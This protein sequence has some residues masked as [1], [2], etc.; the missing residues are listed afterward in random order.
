MGKINRNLFAVLLFIPIL[1]GVFA[2]CDNSP[3]KTGTLMDFVPENAAVVF[4]ISNFE[5]L[6]ADMENSA[7][8]S[9]FENTEIYSYFTKKDKILKN[10]HPTSQSLLSINKVNDSVSAYTFITKH[11]DKLFQLD[12]VKNKSVETLTLDK[13]SF[14]RVSIDENTAYSTIIDSVLVVSS[15]QQIIQDIL[16]GKTEHDATFKKVFNLPSSNDFTALLRGKKEAIN[17]STKINFT[18]WSALDITFSSENFTATG[19]SMATDTIPQLLNIFEGQIPQQNDVALLIPSDAK[20]ALSFTFNDAESIQEKIRHYKGDTKPI[21]TTGIFGSVSEAG[22]IELKQESAIF[23]KSIDALLT[24]DALARFVTSK[25]SFREVDIKSFSEPKLFRE[26]FSPLINSEKANYVFQLD[27]FFVFTESEISA[28]QIISDYQNNN[29]LKNTSYFE[30]TIVDL[31]TA[32]SL[33]VLKLQGELSES[34]SMFFQN[35]NTFKNISFEKF[36][37]AA[38]QFSYDRNFAHVTLSCKEVGGNVKKSTEK[39]SEKFNVKLE[40]TILNAPKLVK[41][42]NGESKIVVQDI[43]NKLYFISESGKILWTKNLDSAILGEVEEVSI[44]GNKHIAFTTKNAFYLLDRNGKDSKSFPIKFKD[45]VTQ[46]LSVFDYDNNGN[47]RFVVIQDKEVLMYDKNAKVVTGFGFKKAKSSIVQSPIHIRMG[48][49]DYIVI[50]EEN[51]SLNILSRVGKS[52]VSV[53][54]K[55]NFSNIPIAEEDNTFV[56]ITKEN[57]KERISQD[58]KVSSLKL[59]VG[60]NYWFTIS[61]NTKATLDDNLLRIN[62][63]LAELPLGIYTQPQL[64]KINRSYYT[65]ITE[66][67]EKKVY[68]FDENGKLQNG[69]PVY[70]TSEASLSQGKRTTNLVV[71]GDADS[72]IMYSM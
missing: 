5:N 20:S 46:P 23:I 24:S 61:G 3:S 38:L 53:S 18:S 28:Q 10:L 22:I 33:L 2:S 59:D 14:Q 40:N 52:R 51:G 6:Q 60:A 4:K 57:T 55:F 16:N 50:A 25:S 8:L 1:L 56:V 72:V 69:F 21:Q 65:T 64:Y 12:S 37:L 19:I 11:T 26:T 49:K 7:L 32:S 13:K 36:P 35:D 41:T 66:T 54:K 9:K 62:G 15:S 27:N 29:T 43:T 47:Y 67:Q 44:S 34:L 70:G 42:K 48:S 31:S 68:V 39:V 30:N 45:D 71:K 63:K 58:G 17:D